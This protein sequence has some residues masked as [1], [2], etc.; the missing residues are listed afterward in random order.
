M[1]KKSKN[2]RNMLYPIVALVLFLA[3]WEML[4]WALDVNPII[5]PSPRA[6]FLTMV[7]KIQFIFVSSANTFLG[8]LGGFLIAFV[9]AVSLA[10][11][12]YFSNILEKSIL[13]FAV[14]TRAIPTIA[15]APVVVLWFGTDALSKT[16]LSAFAAFFPIL[17]N[18]TKGLNSVDRDVIDLMKTYSATKW[19]I[20]IKVRVPY[21][22]PDLF[23]GL[24]VASS[25]AVIG[26]IISEYVG[27]TK[28]IGYLIKS[29]TYYSETDL[30]FAGIAAASFVGMFLYWL[31]ELVEK[32]V[33]YWGAN[34]RSS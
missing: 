17:I 9:V 29:S 34:S 27:V 10:T 16:L 24:K 14:A 2:L 31:V 1:K 19:Q 32:R 20:F 33:V 5:I 7:Q 21:A 23:V 13:P 8:A 28:G 12:F 22:L 3:A 26:A 25:F 18:F 15:I 4:V 6:I 30:T 11:V